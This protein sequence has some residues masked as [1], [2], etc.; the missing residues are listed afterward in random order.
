MRLTP[1]AEAVTK[2][3]PYPAASGKPATL[4][5]ET[6]V[7]SWPQ[8][9]SL[10]KTAIEKFNAVDIVV[11][12]AGLFDPQWSHFWE[13]PKTE[14]NPNTVSRDP[15]DSEPGHYA[16]LDVNLTAPI[17][18]SQLAIGHWTK[19]KQQGSLVFIGSIAGY[20]SAPM[21][22]L[23]FASKHGL[24]G[25]VRSLGALRK[26][27][28]I[29]VGCVAPGAVAVSSLIKFPMESPTLTMIDTYASER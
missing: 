26:E 2:E 27:L 1:E 7:T 10:W 29:R 22:P 18:L 21:T 5:H 8:L 4:F 19:N 6:N 20:T 15:S 14:T 16:V 12:G 23:Y 9:T 25:F 13:A 28:G 17:R 11:N 3:Y 24:H